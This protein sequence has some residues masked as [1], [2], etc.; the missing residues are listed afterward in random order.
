[1]CTAVGNNIFIWSTGGLYRERRA[2]HGD[3]E[4]TGRAGALPELDD[5]YGTPA[6]LWYFRRYLG[7]CH[8]KVGCQVS[9]VR[10]REVLGSLEPSLQ[11]LTLQWGVH[12]ARFPNLF[13][14]RVNA[15][16]LAVLYRLLCVRIQ[17]DVVLIW[18]GKHDNE[19]LFA[20]FSRK[21]RCLGFNNLSNGFSVRSC[22]CNYFHDKVTAVVNY[23]ECR[24]EN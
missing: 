7:L 13:T 14:L 15:T 18:F 19:P 24:Y 21:L 12:G 23:S 1:M 17:E 16:H 11:M 8:S 6:Q 3:P 20:G 22:F 2:D 4:P 5:S 9:S 10:E